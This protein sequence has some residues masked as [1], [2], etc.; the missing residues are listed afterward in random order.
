MRCFLAIEP[1]PLASGAA[2]RV[3]EVI[4]RLDPR[5]RAQKWVVPQNLHLT[6]R[7]LGELTQ[8]DVDMLCERLDAAMP[9]MEPFSL[10]SNGMGVRPSVGR[11]RVLWVGFDDADGCFSSLVAHVDLACER[12]GLIVESRPQPP[13]LTL[14]R[15]RGNSAI[16]TE[17]IDA[18]D[19]LV[20]HGQVIVSVPSFSLFISRLAPRGP[21]YRI[22]GT[23]RLRGE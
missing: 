22:I 14:C 8:G 1:G 23:W 15:S 21:Q 13:H 18:G 5:W 4:E 19:A 16:R 12:A 6:V 2:A 10:R 20:R 3:R 7:F 11:A 9:L 17:A